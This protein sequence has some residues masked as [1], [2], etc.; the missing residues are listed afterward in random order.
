[1]KVCIVG[2]GAI[3]G[4]LAGWMG[5][6]LPA[7]TV[8]L[9]A[10]AR[11]ATLTAVRE[12]GLVLETADGE[13]R[14]AVRASADATELGVQDLV[15]LAVKGPA[16]SAVVP[17]VRQL[18]G[19]QTQLLT[20]MNGVPWWFF[21]GLP[22]ACHGL[23]LHS[24]DPGGTARAHIPSAQVLGG[25][26][27]LSASSPAPGRVRHVNGNNFI[28]GRAVGEP[29]TALQQVATLLQGAGLAVTVSDRI[30]R[31]VWFKLWGNMTMN[32]VSAL[33]GAPCDRILDDPLVRGFCSAVMLEAQHIGSAFGIPIE[34]DPEARHA[35]TR[36]LG[37]F[38]TSMLQDLLAG[39]PL[40]IDALVGAVREVGQ[41]L[42]QS[43]PSIDALLGLVRLM[44]A[45]RGLYVVAA[46]GR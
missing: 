35:V 6:R 42:G 16:L 27:H 12:N 29:D 30:Q 28:I 18:M 32:P 44:A 9:S 36:K 10:L 20:A 34:Q 1:M 14:V 8:T 2:L 7:G 25:V 22:G 43:T 15:I 37:S 46:T 39:R 41:H 40:E 19:P 31:E 5:T 4:L 24:V 21:D 17:A 45:E 26:V 33:T 11:G 23:S 3:G 38:K 13:Q